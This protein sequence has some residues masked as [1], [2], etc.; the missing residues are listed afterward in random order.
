MAKR[1]Q[2]ALT[3]IAPFADRT[4]FF[5]QRFH[6]R[7]DWARDILDD[8]GSLPNFIWHL[9]SSFQT[10]FDTALNGWGSYAGYAYFFKHDQYVRYDW[11][12]NRVDLGPASISPSWDLGSSFSSDLDAAMNGVG[13]YEGK[14]YFFKGSQYARYDWTTEEVDLVAPLSAWNLPAGFLSGIDAAVN[15]LGPYDG[16]LYFF[17]DDEF[18]SYDWAAGTID[19]GYPQKISDGWSSLDGM[20]GFPLRRVILYVTIDPF[21]HHT[22]SDAGYHEQNFQGLKRI[23]GAWRPDVF[24]DDF[25]CPQID[26][27]IINDPHLLALFLGGSGSEWVEVYRQLSWS[28]MLGTFC[29]LIKNTDVPIL[30]VCGSHQLI[31]QAFGGWEAVAHMSEAGAPPMTIAAESDGVFRA[32]NPR[33]GE[34]GVFPACCPSVGLMAPDPILNNA[35][36]QMFFV[37]SHHDQVI[38]SAVSAV[39]SPLLVP[40]GMNGVVQENVDLGQTVVTPGQPQVAFAHRPVST[41]DERCQIQALRY[42]VDP[43]GRILYTTQ[44]HPELTWDSAHPGAARALQDSSTFLTNFLEIAAQY[45][46]NQPT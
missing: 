4:Y 41:P 31:A 34:R 3:G 36:A 1:I 22:S 38:A 21:D 37:E 9:P 27:T 7:Y 13:P 28:A 8:R 19:P 42:Q 14:A 40:D 23:A 18:L 16:K 6:R 30:A 20:T 33:I 17:K 46:S 39:A 25:W 10:G 32:P 26:Q 5:G 43:P 24:V 12:T 44:F 2:A 45:W 15:G 35:S 11:K 29:S